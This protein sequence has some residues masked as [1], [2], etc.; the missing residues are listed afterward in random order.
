[1]TARPIEL[2]GP[3]TAVVPYQVGLIAATS[4]KLGMRIRADRDLEYFGRIKLSNAARAESPS[5]PMT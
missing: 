2:A 4:T 3:A 5:P 1:M